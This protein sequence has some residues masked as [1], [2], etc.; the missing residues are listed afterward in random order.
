MVALAVF[1][2]VDAGRK[3]IHAMQVTDATQQVFE[4]SMGFRRQ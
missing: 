1:D 4:Q 3:G 2:C